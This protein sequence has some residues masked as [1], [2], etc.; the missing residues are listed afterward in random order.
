MSIVVSCVSSVMNCSAGAYWASRRSC[1]LAKVDER[2]CLRPKGS[3]PKGRQRTVPKAFAQ[4]LSIA[5]PISFPRIASGMLG[6]LRRP[7][8]L[9]VSEADDLG[10]TCLVLLGDCFAEAAGGVPAIP[11]SQLQNVHSAGKS[12]PRNAVHLAFLGGFC[13]GTPVSCS[14]HGH[15]LCKRPSRQQAQRPRCAHRRPGGSY[16]GFRWKRPKKLMPPSASDQARRR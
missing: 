4:R 8:A 1:V 13:A 7:S 14:V 9:S 3:S 2:L 5:S 10:L 16:F 12:Y 11:L 15:R 6:S